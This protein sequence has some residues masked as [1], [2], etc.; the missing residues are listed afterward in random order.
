MFSLLS[1]FCFVFVPIC[2]LLPLWEQLIS[3]VHE[4]VPF[5]D[6]PERCLIRNYEIKYEIKYEIT[7]TSVTNTKLNK[8]LNTKLSGRLRQIRN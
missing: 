4:G 7:W 3:V 6:G 8:K 2:W 5:N 1:N